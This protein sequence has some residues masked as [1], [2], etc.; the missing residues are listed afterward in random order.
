MSKRIK[1]NPFS[2]SEKECR[3]ITPKITDIDER[4]VRFEYAKKFADEIQVL[5]GERITA[6]VNGSFVFGDFIEAFIIKNQ[7]KVKKMTLSTLS[8][9]DNNIDSLKT[10]MLH[11]YVDNLNIIVSDYFYGHER[12]DLIP[13]TYQELDNE[14]NT[15]QLAIE[16]THCKVY[17][18][19]TYDDRYFVL[20][21]SV[22]LRSSGNTENFSFE[23]NKQVYTFYDEYLSAIL[24][25]NKTIDKS[26][27]F[28]KSWQADQHSKAVES[29]EQDNPRIQQKNQVRQKRD[30]QKRQSSRNNK[31]HFDEFSF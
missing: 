19:E 23:D 13:Y 4:F 25:R 21:G 31:S 11:G 24:E 16:R 14:S 27:K 12:A 15:F 5:K 17:I 7:I 20:Q 18:F 1:I 8:Y 10:L 26:L 22:N 28:K 2:Q 6:I 30:G 3:Y 29:P 9:N